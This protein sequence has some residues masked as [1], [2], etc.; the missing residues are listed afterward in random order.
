MINYFDEQIELL[1]E[2]NDEI[3]VAMELINNRDAFILLGNKRL[4]KADLIN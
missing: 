4:T 1:S 2:E 3:L